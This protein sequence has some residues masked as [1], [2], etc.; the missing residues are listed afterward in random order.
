MSF[1]KSAGVVSTILVILALVAT[2]LKQV[3]ALVGFLMTAI[4]IFIVLAF[5]VVIVGVGVMVFR[6]WSANRKQKS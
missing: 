5:V 2:L 3:I 6:T 4:Q 1:V